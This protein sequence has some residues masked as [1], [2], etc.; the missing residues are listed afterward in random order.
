[1]GEMGASTGI[2][3]STGMGHGAM[4][5]PLRWALAV[6]ADMHLALLEELERVAPIWSGRLVECV[7]S[8]LVKVPVA[9]LAAHFESCQESA[10]HLP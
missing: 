6:P 7:P 2:G 10:I 9:R 5:E 1:M 8:D 4:S 3:K